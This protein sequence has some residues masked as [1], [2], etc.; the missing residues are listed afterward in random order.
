M[1]R[2]PKLPPLT[3][4]HFIFDLSPS[5]LIIALD[6]LPIIAAPYG[7]DPIHMKKIC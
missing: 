6:P 5:V 2:G 3:I 4:P 7:I 1:Q